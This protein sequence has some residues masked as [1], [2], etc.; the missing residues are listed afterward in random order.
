MIEPINDLEKLILVQPEVITGLAWG[1]PRSGHPEGK[2]ETHVEQLLKGIERLYHVEPD[3]RRSLRIIAILHDAFKYAVDYEKPKVG[4]NN[5]AVMARNFTQRLKI[6]EAVLDVIEHH[7][8]HF[9]IWR[10][11]EKNGTVR[12]SEIREIARKL[13]LDLYLEFIYLERDV[14]QR[15]PRTLEWFTRKLAE[16]LIGQINGGI[17]NPLK[18]ITCDDDSHVYHIWDAYNRYGIKKAIDCV[19]GLQDM[20]INELVRQ[21][22]DN[23][24]RCEGPDDYCLACCD[25]N[26]AVVL[27]REIALAERQ[28]RVN[29]CLRMDSR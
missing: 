25:W 9:S 6:N 11:F 17:R 26:P 10:T 18:T 8:K 19:V 14:G 16:A 24:C 22:N 29:A 27:L 7:D 2:V 20:E 5:H 1:Q 21:I 13:D 15:D 3:R 4:A 23:A 28:L 12:E